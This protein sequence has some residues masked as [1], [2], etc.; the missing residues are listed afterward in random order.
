ME[1]KDTILL[2]HHLYRASVKKDTQTYRVY[3]RKYVLI[4]PE[5]LTVISR[6]YEDYIPSVVYID[7]GGMFGQ[8]GNIYLTQDTFNFENPTVSD[9]FEMAHA[10]NRRESS[11]KYDFKT[12]TVIE[13]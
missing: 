3:K 1:F 4:V 8:N 5:K 9:I 12:N 2:P 10:L 11:Y 6:D 13:R 7:I